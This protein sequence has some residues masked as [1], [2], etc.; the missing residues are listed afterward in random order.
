MSKTI[1]GNKLTVIINNANNLI[2]ILIKAKN[3]IKT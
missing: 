3:K 2:M 1:E